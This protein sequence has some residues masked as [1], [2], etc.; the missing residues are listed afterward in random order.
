MTDIRT[1]EISGLFTRWLERYSP[2]RSMDG[3]AR[4]QQDETAA[5]LGVILRFAPKDGYHGFVTRVLDQ[6][7]SQMKTR[8][9]PTVHEL[10]AVCS[11]AR[12]EHRSDALS[13]DLDMTPEGIT[14]RKMQ[15]GEPVGEGWLWGANAV[16]LI[17]AKLVDQQ[18]MEKYRSGAFLARRAVY[19]EESAL[20]WEAEAKERHEAAKA[21]VRGENG[22]RG[23]GGPM[24]D[25]R[26]AVA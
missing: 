21:V 13:V 16:A 11:N 18:T 15:R 8:A 10:G 24:P 4:A 3:N 25:K 5:L 23:F 2:P 26:Q 9:W 20:A 22:P 1:A 6:C 12:K 19:G 14:A 7:S 17:R